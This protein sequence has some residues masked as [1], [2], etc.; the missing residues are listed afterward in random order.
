M[1][2]GRRESA[3]TMPAGANRMLRGRPQPIV[4]YGE[5]PNGAARRGE[6]LAFAGE[7]LPPAFE[8]LGIA[9]QRKWLRQ[10][11]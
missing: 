7:L 11:A 9:L 3:R 1:H 5:S 2:P 6:T 10:Q 8:L 4:K